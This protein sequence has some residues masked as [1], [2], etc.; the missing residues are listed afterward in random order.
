VDDLAMVLYFIVLDHFFD[1]STGHFASGDMDLYE[2][3]TYS[4]LHNLIVEGH[5]DA[6]LSNFKAR[7]GIMCHLTA[8][9]HQLVKV[10]PYDTAV[11][12]QLGI[13]PMHYAIRWFILLFCAGTRPAVHPHPLRRTVCALQ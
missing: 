10:L 11:L 8:F 9:E 13:T 6:L 1:S 3:L 12:A 2:V 4:M 5:M 7:N